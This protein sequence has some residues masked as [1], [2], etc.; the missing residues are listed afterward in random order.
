VIWSSDVAEHTKHIA[1]VMAAL[2][3]AH[4]YCNPAK[5][6]FYLKE[7]DFLGHHISARGIEPNSSKVDCVLNWP[8]PTSATEVRS[9]L[10]LVRYIAVFLPHLADHTVILTPLTTKESRKSFPDWTTEHQTAFDVIKALV[11]SA[12]CLTTIDHEC[13][14]WNHPL[15]PYCKSLLMPP[16]LPR[17]RLVM[18]M[19]IF[20]NTSR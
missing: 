12:N 7:L 4:L 14:L 20:A 9:F 17:L 19:M 13:L 10:G 3:K 6:W 5:C 16:Y 2:H 18:S 1:L 8:V 15:T 11:V